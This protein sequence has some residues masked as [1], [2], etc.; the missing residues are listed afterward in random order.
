MDVSAMS[1]TR[2]GPVATRTAMMSQYPEDSNTVDLGH[3]ANTDREEEDDVDE[4]A[5]PCE[6]Y[7]IRETP[8]VFYPVRIGETINLAKEGRPQSG[9]PM[10][11]KS[12]RDVALK[13]M[14]TRMSASHQLLEALESLHKGGIV[15]RGGLQNTGFSVGRSSEPSHMTQDFGNQEKTRGSWYGPDTKPHPKF[16]LSAIKARAHP[17]SNP[18][19]RQHIL[20]IMTQ[21]FSCHPRKRPTATQLLQDSS[22]RAI[23]EKY[24]H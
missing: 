13:S 1:F 8:H 19:E 16:L 22:F 7:N 3:F 2:G 11:F 14:S 23:M 17:E 20:P 10:I 12:K 9:W 6:K 24:C 4:L 18:I 15:H 21:G 5:E